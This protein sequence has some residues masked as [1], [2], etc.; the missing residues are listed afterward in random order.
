LKLELNDRETNEAERI[1][2]QVFLL[3]VS[4]NLIKSP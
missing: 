2:A 3:F 1:N 4:D